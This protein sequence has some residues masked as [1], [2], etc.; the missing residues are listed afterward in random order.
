M[1]EQLARLGQPGP[2]VIGIDELSIGPRHTYRIVVSDLFRRR[3][4]WFGGQDRSEASLDAF[5]SWLGPKKSQRIRLVVLSM[6]KAFCNS[7]PKSALA[8][9]KLWQTHLQRNAIMLIPNGEGIADVAALAL[10]LGHPLQDCLYLAVAR[11]HKFPLLTADRKF[12]DKAIATYTK[13]TLLGK[14]RSH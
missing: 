3:P 14:H 4:N 7:T 12:R 13:I 10:E 5:Y 9:C 1:G 11:R 6:W 8:H 2:E